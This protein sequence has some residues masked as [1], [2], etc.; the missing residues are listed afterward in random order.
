MAIT[1]L[2][3]RLIILLIPGIIATLR[4]ERLTVHAR[5]SHFRFVIYSILLGGTSYLAI[6]II[7]YFCGL[8]N[9]LRDGFYVPIRL[10]FW[11]SLFD[12]CIPISI[13]EV[14]LTCIFSIIF[15]FIIT[16]FNQTKC[17]QFIARK[18]HI[19]DKYGEE[20]LYSFFLDENYIYCVWVRD[21]LHGLTYEG[22]VESF[23]ESETVRELVL[24]DVKVYRYDDSE[25]LYEI[26]AV[27]L[28]YPIG[29]LN[30]E[31][32]PIIYEEKENEE[33]L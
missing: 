5:W 29:I 10:K 28:S 11:E 13:E 1:E 25:F 21:K 33:I 17:L 22:L 15:G 14:I 23:S 7:Y 20:N 3:I 32:P 27:Y 30:I 6:Q 4:V 18:L 12:A 2:T 26:P 9:Y 8:F 19:S 31:V 16:K 24:N